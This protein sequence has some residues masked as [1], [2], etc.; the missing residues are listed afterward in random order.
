MKISKIGIL[1]IKG[2]IGPKP[3]IVKKKGEEV[4]RKSMLGH[5]TKVKHHVKCPQ[6]RGSKFG[7]IWST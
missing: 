5:M 7:K 1:A 6:L 2:Q 3:A 4:S